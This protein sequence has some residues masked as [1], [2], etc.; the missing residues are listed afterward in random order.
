MKQ[1]HF[2][3]LVIIVIATM[4]FSCNK[5]K[6]KN[7]GEYTEGLVMYTGATEVDGCG[8]MLKIGDIVYKPLNLPT[9]YEKDSLGVWIKYNVT[10]DGFQCG[11][12]STLKTTINLVEIK[13]K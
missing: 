1:T 2:T 6:V 10:A 12:V 4:I 8:Y 13:K 9:D 7:A 11:D 5:E 3:W